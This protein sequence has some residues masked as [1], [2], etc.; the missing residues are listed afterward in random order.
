MI[1]KPSSIIFLSAGIALWGMAQGNGN[2]GQGA[3]E[4]IAR[5]PGAE[6]KIR[7]TLLTV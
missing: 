3:V 2:A 6:G 4:G 1:V 5:Q 7:G